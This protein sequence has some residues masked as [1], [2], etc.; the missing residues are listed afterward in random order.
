MHAI[1]HHSTYAFFFFFGPTICPT[2]KK[3]QLFLLKNDNKSIAIASIKY[4]PDKKCTYEYDRFI[5]IN[6]HRTDQNM[7]YALIILDE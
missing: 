1:I 5:S 4:V 6:Q 3:K 2:N 7:D